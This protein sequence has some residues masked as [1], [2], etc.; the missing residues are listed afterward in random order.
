[1]REF[2]SSVQGKGKSLTNLRQNNLLETAVSF[3]IVGLAIDAQNDV[4]GNMR[5]LTLI[6]EH[7]ALEL[8]VGEKLYWEGP[9][10]FATGRLYE[11][12]GGSA[13]VYQQFGFPAVQ[14]ISLQGRHVV[15]VNPL[16]SFRV[17]FTTEGM[18]AGEE[19]AATPD[20]DTKIRFVCSLKGILR[21]PVQ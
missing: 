2:F 3:R 1:V 14:G 9:I 20:A 10:R 4:A 11:E 12:L 5:S 7:S 21:R 16:Q 18:T 19:T 17:K 13:D 6:Q 8:R 15:D